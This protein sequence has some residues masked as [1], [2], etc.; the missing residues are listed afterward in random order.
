MKD[1][2]SDLKK[3]IKKWTC[4]KVTLDQLFSEQ[5]P[6]NIVK[7]L[8]GIGKGSKNH[9]K[10]PSETSPFESQANSSKPSKQK[11]W[12]RPCKHYRLK[13]YLSGDYY[14][15][16]KCST[17]GSNDHLTKEHTEQTAIKKTLNKLKAQLH[18]K[19]T[20]KKSH[21][22]P[23]PFNDCKYCGF[24]NHHSDDCEF[25]HGCEI[26]GSIAHEIADYPKN[27]RNNKKPK[28]SGPKVVFGD[29]SLGDTEGYGSV[30][31]KGITFTR[32]AYVNGLKHNLI[33]VSQLCDVN[34]KVLFTK[35][36]GTI[37]N[38]ND[39]VV[40]IP[41]RRRDVDHLGK[42]DEK[43]D[44]GFS[45]GY[46]LVAKAFITSTKGDEVN[47]NEVSSFPDD[48]FLKPR[49]R[50]T[51]VSANT[52]YFPYVPAFDCLSSNNHITPETITPTE[53]PVPLE[54]VTLEDPPDDV[55]TPT[56]SP[57]DDIVSRPPVPHD[58]WLREKH[59]ELV[60]I[61]GEPLTSITT[62][63]RVRD[64]EAASAHECLYVKFISKMEPKKLIEALKE[65]GY[66]SAMQEE[67]NQFERNKVRTL[68]PKPYGKTIIGTKWIWKN[69]MDEHGVVAKNKERLFAQGYNQQKGINYEE[70]FALVVKLE[71]I[72][73][74]L[75]YAAYMGF[76]GSTFGGCQ[77]LGG[78]LVCWSA[79]KQSSVAMSS[80]E[81]EYV[82]AA[83]CCAQVLW[84][85][86]Q[87]ADYDVLY[88]KDHILKGDIEPYFVP[89][90]LQLAD[91]FTK[92]LAEPSFTRLVAE[93]E[94]SGDY[95]LVPK[96]ET[97]EA[98]LAT[99]RLV[100]EDHPSLSSSTL[101]NLSP[102]K[103]KYFSP[104]WK[105]AELSTE[106]IQSLIP[107]S[108]EVNAMD[109]TDKSLSGTSMPLVT[110]PKPPTTTRPRKKKISYSTQPEVLKTSRIA[111]S[112]SSQ[113]THLQPV[114]EFVAT[115]DTTKSIDA[116]ESVEV[117]GNQPETVDTEK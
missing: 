73:I 96:K 112:S 9:I 32:V 40:L 117:Q 15:K 65:E 50:D 35:T 26:F 64:S 92:P 101:I 104:R 43:A 6:G 78:K 56:I 86:S 97:V 24:N 27:L 72:R 91:I 113:A 16:P 1:E 48:E 95:V 5:V 70:T 110:Q 8:R 87:L 74:F 45:L 69:K 82:A 98:G 51:Q 90:D 31:Y 89:T 106:P 58:R 29:I 54:Y 62:R 19:P 44:D 85:K 36:Q 66:V 38:Q 60:N 111:T 11:A 77:I 10:I 63:S 81:A 59:I 4:S 115:A 109:T 108:G 23:K 93:L 46:S 103:V 33:S 105:V 71:E 12:Y 55:P 34:F 88:D 14:S 2:I 21:R 37:F 17:C 100:D 61:I 49:C 39:E 30:N 25:Y 47:F 99:L 79:K 41:P 107:P 80:A 68:V 102:M 84:I 67:L 114:E 94:P 13:N 57:L 20:L 52:K 18:L 22:I 53:S 83:E 28:E 75:A 42:F 116:S 76:C 3:V 7:A